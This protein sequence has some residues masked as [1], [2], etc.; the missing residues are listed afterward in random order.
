MAV[1]TAQSLM[2]ARIPGRVGRDIG[3]PGLEQSFDL[4]S[5][6]APWVAI[7]GDHTSGTIH[8]TCRHPAHAGGQQQYDS[9]PQ[10]DSQQPNEQQME[11]WRASRT[12]MEVTHLLRALI[13][14]VPQ[15]VDASLAAAKWAVENHHAVPSCAENAT[16]CGSESQYSDAA[17]FTTLMVRGI[18]ASFTLQGLL[19]LWPVDGTW[20][21]L[22]FPLRGDGRKARGYAF[23]NFVDEALA[24][25]FRQRW[26]S[27]H[28]SLFSSGA[29]LDISPASLQGARLVALQ[30]PR[31]P[32]SPIPARGAATG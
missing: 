18:P 5:S 8:S 31:P 12:R 3:V 24:T 15:R 26:Q 32:R 9:Q 7:S 29:G 21:L 20:D 10:H 16:A 6:S 13:S 19:D 11:Q 1:T 23:M 17:A 28:V 2:P 14:R 27:T 4:T 25:Q 22:Y 30:I